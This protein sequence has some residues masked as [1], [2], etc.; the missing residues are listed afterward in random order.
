MSIREYS[1]LPI[2]TTS[3]ALCLYREMKRNLVRMFLCW[4]P[5]SLGTG[6]RVCTS[7]HKEKPSTPQGK[8]TKWA[9]PAGVSG[10][11]ASRRL[12]P[13]TSPFAR[14]H[15][16]TKGLE[17]RALGLAFRVGSLHIDGP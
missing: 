1:R 7:P 12:T 6:F 15:A 2:S 11:F 17:F 10:S 5:Q 16:R 8:L 14:R 13:L 3:Q 4:G 9:Y